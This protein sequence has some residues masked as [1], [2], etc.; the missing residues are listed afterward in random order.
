MKEK[1]VLYM[2]ASFAALSDARR[3][4]FSRATYL[5]NKKQEVIESKG[6]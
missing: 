3:N 4:R 1:M 5:L 2:I 6:I